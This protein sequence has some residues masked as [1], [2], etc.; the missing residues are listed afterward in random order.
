MRR[1]L[2][3]LLLG[4]LSGGVLAQEPFTLGV[5]GQKTWTIS[6]GI[7]DPE[8]LALEGIYPGQ[9]YL[10]QSLWAD[11]T[12]QALGLLTV[13]ASFNDQLGPGFQHFVLKLDQSP[14][15]GELGDFYVDQGELGVYNKKLLGIRLTYQDEG[16]SATSLAARLEGIS[17]S[18]TFQ[19]QAA[20]TEVLFSYEDP[21]DPWEPAPYSN[22]L[23]GAY[24]WPLR[25]PFVEG[26]SEVTLSLP[27]STG[28][29]AF[30]ED[31][32]L[33]WLPEALEEE[34]EVDLYQGDYLVLRD[35]GDVL[36]LRTSPKVL[37]RR[38]IQD[39]IDTYNDLHDLS[40][41]E[42]KTY[43]FI[44]DS[45]LE[46]AF[47]TGL[48][49]YA[50]LEVSEEGYP[51]S[52]MG[53]R[54][55][56]LLGEEDVIEGS[57]ELWVRPAGQEE[58]LPISEPQFSD[59]SWSL[60]PEEGVL[61]I[62]FPDHF[63]QE[64][65]ALKASFKYRQT[66]GVYMLGLSV[67]PG[68]ERV[69]LNGKPLSRG[70][71]YTIDYE[72]GVLV[73]FIAL[74][75]DDE[76]KVDF[77]RQR[78]GLGGYAEYE[79]V[80]FGASLEY[81]GAV[82]SVYRAVDLGRPD[83]STPVMPNTH[84]VAGLRTAGEVGDWEYVLSF[85]ASENVFPEDD[86]E[87]IAAQN[88][89]NDI[90]ALSAPDGEYVV[91]A[92]QNGITIY[93]QGAFSSYGTGQGLGGRAVRGLL[94]LPDRLL[95][96][97]DSGLTVVRLWDASP[98]DRVASW[99]RIY[100]D[101]G[102]PGEEGLA[103]AG[104]EGVVYLATDQAVAV[105]PPEEAEDP[106]AWTTLP[107]PEGE[108]PRALAASGGRLYLGGKEGLY[109]WTGAD[110]TKLGSVPGQVNDL[111]SEGE[112]LYVAT[113]QGVRILKSGAGAG[114]LSAGEEAHALTSFQGELW[115]GTDSG[116]YSKGGKAPL[117]EGAFTALGG[118][119]A[120]WAG[121]R[122]DSDYNL[123]LWQ[124]SPELR[125]F[126]QTET[127]I[128][129]QDLGH[130]QDL[131]ASDHTA[132]GLVGNL[133]LSRRLGDWDLDLTAR[134]RWPG[135]QAIGTTSTSD[136]HGIG[137]AASYDGQ[138]LSFSLQGGWDVLDLFTSPNWELSGAIAATW[139]GVPKVSLRL[140]P[141]YSP[142][143]GGFE[144]GFYLDSNWQG[145]LWR[146]QATLSGGVA[147]PAWYTAGRLTASFTWT[148]S[149]SW[150]LEAQA[151]RPFRS[152]GD[153]GNEKLVL[154]LRWTEGAGL[155]S[156]NAY[157]TENLEHHLLDPAWTR[158]S[159][160]QVDLRLK[161]WEFP[162]GRL[163][164]RASLSLKSAPG[165]TRWSVKGIGQ[166]ELG[167]E[168]FQ[169][170]VTFGQ[171]FRPASQRRERTLA[172]S[173]RWESRAWEGLKPILSWERSW[174]LLYHP[175][176]GE[177]LTQDQE[178][179]LRLLWQSDLPWTNELTL[180]YE[181]EG[182]LEL[183][184]RFS[185]PLELGTISLFASANFEEGELEGK[186]SASYG[187]PLMEGWDMGVEV[188]YVLGGSRSSG[189]VQGLYGRLSLVASF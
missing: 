164:P 127:L 142:A 83:P 70:T 139:D 109:L 43:P 15:H 155:V 88:R 156:W 38:R 133:S 144:T 59:F 56:L 179:T 50:V 73:L 153:P 31:Y 152:Q 26:F 29:E 172:L 94:A 121:T 24:F 45:D 44:L 37:L 103:V 107:L 11:I 181:D 157:W 5:T 7:G 22:Q 34:P 126:D 137:F 78:G 20:Q 123:D 4:A 114:W 145:E 84:S 86:N 174:Q 96:A 21:E 178:A 80:F 168:G 146:A 100:Q 124:V 18:L 140:T 171:G 105:F 1:V 85:G 64:G 12:G 3:L 163:A 75:E 41:S 112:T 25:A 39:A 33:E 120:L 89:I 165:E 93:H 188:G 167:K 182:A 66:G 16:F 170:G 47:L 115:W 132:R 17:E 82:V 6:Y 87:R 13:E 186:V 35:E 169:L 63:F 161:A 62:S 125:R 101:D 185:W 91:F 71:D 189:P 27:V 119:D 143:E 53:R 173:L 99:V 10:D 58:F 2:F 97:T 150:R 28:L 9:L 77:E 30:L 131:S 184:D 90:V 147:G 149:S 36:I 187:Q 52:G 14:W 177:K 129:G 49:D 23:E 134:T 48:F 65:A 106:T 116:L 67:V 135:Y 108:E 51:F 60:Y 113:D 57:L 128:D 162:G 110:W 130:Y 46:D 180:T 98:F 40:G 92:H 122:A 102:F 79:R 68:S 54:R 61:R 69:Y 117:L 19:G 111:L 118:G 76:L 141:V 55:Y 151:L 32:G 104:G 138:G 166:L 183:V 95:C 81:G 148:P 160:G 74:T 154:S 72:T 159:T 175:Q 42:R 158:S 136:S 8:A 176:Y